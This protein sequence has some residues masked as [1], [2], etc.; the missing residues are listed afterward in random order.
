MLV[1]AF[2][3]IHITLCLAIRGRFFSVCRYRNS[4][5][6]TL[7]S[8]PNVTSLRFLQNDAISV[9]FARCHGFNHISH[10]PKTFFRFLCDQY[11]DLY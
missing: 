4:R 6:S 7:S 3:N 2:P 1:Y 8:K 11:V 10:N 9:I 5:I